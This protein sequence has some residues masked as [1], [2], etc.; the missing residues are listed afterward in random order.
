MKQIYKYILL[1]ITTCAGCFSYGQDVSLYQQYNGRYAFTFMGNTLN[2]MENNIQEE[3]E[4]LSESSATLNLQPG[5]QIVNAYLYWA[6]S[7][8][9]DFEVKL[10][11]QT[12]NADRTFLH[13]RLIQNIPYEFFGAFADI[14]DLVQQT[15]N[16]SYTFSDLDISDV[17]PS[18]FIFKTNFAG[19]AIII[20]YENENLPLNQLN[21][22]DGLQGVPNTLSITLDNLNVIDNIGFRIGFLAWEGDS[23][24]AITES[25]RINGVVIGNPP[26]NPINNA[27]NSTNSITGATN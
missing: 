11:N 2:V 23:T 27:F 19:W 5:D 10:N 26:L 8:P 17:L 21:V 13:E 9:G 12:I 4:I 7:G 15:G 24:L 14:T 22:Y 6:G 1:F 18:H 20:V 25:L 16:G 3:L